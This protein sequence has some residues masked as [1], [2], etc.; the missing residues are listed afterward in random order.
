MKSKLF[1]LLLPIVLNGCATTE[2]QTFRVV[3]NSNAELAQ[4]ATDAD[5]SRYDRLLA[6]EMGIFFPQGVAVPQ[7]DLDR[8]RQIFR[9]TFLDELEGYR[10]VGKPGVSTMEVQAS[11]IDLRQATYA[12]IPKL[13]RDVREIARPGSFVFLMEMRDSRT[14]RVL[15]RAADTASTP[16]LATAEGTQ[17]DWASVEQS[18]RRWATLFRQFLDSNLKQE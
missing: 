11:L 15:A 1:M 14:D 2:S 5:F 16:T 18:V 3:N 4:V 9:S 7:Q 10:I 6:D 8:I 17:T 13:R 12:D